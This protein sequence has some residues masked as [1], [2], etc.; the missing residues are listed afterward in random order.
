[1]SPEDRLR[2]ALPALRLSLT[3]DAP[4][5]EDLDQARAVAAWTVEAYLATSELDQDE[6]QGWWEGPTLAVQTSGAAPGDPFDRSSRLVVARFTGLVVNLYDGPPQAV[7]DQLDESADTAHFIP[8]ISAALDHAHGATFDDRFEAASQAVIVDRAELA[9]GWRGLGGLGRVLLAR[10]LRWVAGDAMLIALYPF[11]TEA[12]GAL[13]EPGVA[14]QLVVTQA[15]WASVGFEPWD[16]P[17]RSAVPRRSGRAVAA[18]AAERAAARDSARAVTN[19]QEGVWYACPTRQDYEDR[20]HELEKR[21]GLDR[22]SL[23]R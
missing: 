17:P 13:G 16:P 22:A 2:S 10:G 5:A 4:V 14:E 1:M 6:D 15:I 7:L 11:P 8:I 18:A 21:L 23:R 3:I 20:R 9:A 19:V 12:L